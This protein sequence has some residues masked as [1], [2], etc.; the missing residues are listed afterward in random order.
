M[1]KRS[2]FALALAAALPMSAQAGEVNYN[3]IEAGYSASSI[4]GGDFN[5]WNVDG[6]FGFSDNWYAFGGFETGDDSS[7]DFDQANIGLGWHTT[8]TAQWFVEASWIKDTIDFGAGSDFSDSGYA[9]AGG[10]RGFL[11]DKFE[12]NVKLGYNDV[13]D[14]GDGFTAG[15]AGIYHFNDTWGAYASYDYSDRSDFDINTWGL[16]VRASF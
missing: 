7:V 4:D 9:V 1:L 14:F 3:F 8:G 11:G 13:G 2:L 5:G 12:G 16:G 15:L 6:S 10:V